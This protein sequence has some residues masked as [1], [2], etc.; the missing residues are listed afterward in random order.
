MIVEELPLFRAKVPGFYGDTATGTAVGPGSYNI[1]G[2]R[3]QPNH[4]VA[5][6]SSTSVKFSP[7]QTSTTPGVGTY[8]LTTQGSQK[9]DITIVPFVSKVNRFFGPRVDDVPGP[10]QYSHDG[11]KWGRSGRTHAIG[12]PLSKDAGGTHSLGPGSYDPKLSATGRANPRAAVFGKYS[13]RDAPR[14]ND[15]PGPGHYDQAFSERSV[16]DKKPSSMFAT[17]TGRSAIGSTNTNPAP[18]AYNLPGLFT[19]LEEYRTQKPE[20]FSAF[21]SSASRHAPLDRNNYPGPGSYTGE[22]APRRPQVH[23]KGKGT[24]SFV[25]GTGRNTLPSGTNLGPG[26]YDT[27]KLTKQPR[28]QLA[29]VPFRSLS[30]RFPLAKPAPQEEVFQSRH[31]VVRVPRRIHPSR[32]PNESFDRTTHT[33]SRSVSP[34]Y[35]YDVKYDW[36]KPTCTSG[37]ALS[38]APRFDDRDPKRNFPGPGHYDVSKGSF[39]SSRSLRG[40]WG[41]DGRFKRG[42]E[43]GT[44]GPGYY[45]YD[46]TLYKKSFN[47]TI[48]STEDM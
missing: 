48:G 18:G 7:Q 41:T 11:D 5:P 21:G 44:P 37:S 33:K 26:V 12:M 32:L 42:P 25:S 35:A 6:F 34:D 14:Y 46:T 4:S 16:Y 1:A 47:C 28:Y 15:V 19:S 30:T 10:G 8:D 23:Q 24:S 13:A 2:K 43:G 27:R 40:T 22:I 38:T 31:P 3:A 39:G 29:S 45:A 20:G 36:P 17:K 9:G